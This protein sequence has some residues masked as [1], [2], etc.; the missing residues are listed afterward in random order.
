MKI[1]IFTLRS[2]SP[3]HPRLAAFTEYFKEKNIPYDLIPAQK[4]PIYSRLNWISL[5]FFDNYSILKNSRKIAD[6]DLI[7]IN[8][9]KYLPIARYGKNQN[10]SVIYDTIDNNVFLRAYSL[11]KKIPF[12]GFF[13]KN[14]ISHFSKKEINYAMHYCDRI[15]VNS[16]AL[17]EY[18]AKKADLIYYYSPFENI[19]AVNDCKKQPALLYLGEFSDEKG[20]EEILKLRERLEIELFIY[21]TVSSVTSRNAILKCPQIKHS[22]RIDYAMLT[23]QISEL[24]KKYFLLGTSFIK[25]VHQSYATQEANK[26]IDYL[27]L[28]IPLIGNHRKP[29]EEKILAGC[30]I[31]VENEKDMKRL[32][33]DKNLRN[34]LSGN[35]KDYYFRNYSKEIFRKGLD[36]IFGN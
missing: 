22:E 28:G 5:F 19:G 10:K 7:L 12:T 36:K 24:F 9:L 2:L 29:T 17:Q 8:D 20:A 31:F 13:M 25:P 16:K 27:A 3:M 18:F 23:L 33:G 11:R 30:G 21:G 6:Y 15:I 14:I 34:L 1:G 4:H 32:L 35:C 26:D